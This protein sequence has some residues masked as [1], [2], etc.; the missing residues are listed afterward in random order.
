MKPQKSDFIGIVDLPAVIEDR[1][2]NMHIEDAYKFDI[3]PRLS[4]LA[5]DIYAQGASGRPE[6]RT[7]YTD[8]V[9]EYW[10]RLA[11]YRFYEVHGLNVTQFGVTKTKDPQNTFDQAQEKEKAVRLRRMKTDAEVLYTLLLNEEWKFDN[12]VYRKPGGCSNSS[13]G[14]S[15]GINAIG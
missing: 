11:Y 10:V 1:E 3:K 15:W 14:T 5:S 9:L 4:G 6:L 7:F 12:V 2:I 8:F 13:D